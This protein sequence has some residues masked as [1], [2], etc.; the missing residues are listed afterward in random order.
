MKSVR[1]ILQQITNIL[2]DG[3]NGLKTYTFGKKALICSLKVHT[4]RGT[5]WPLHFKIAVLLKVPIRHEYFVK[6]KHKPIVH[7]IAHEYSLSSTPF[8]QKYAITK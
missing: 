1:T 7:P 6:N 2:L 8:W 3:C 5:A 4:L